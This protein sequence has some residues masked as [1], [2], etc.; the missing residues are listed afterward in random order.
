[1]IDFCR[2]GGPPEIVAKGRASRADL[3]PRSSM[4]L[5]RDAGGRPVRQH[6]WTRIQMYAKISLY[7]VCSPFILL[8]VVTYELE[9]P[10]AEILSVCGCVREGA[11]TTDAGCGK[12]VKLPTVSA[13]ALPMH[14]NRQSIALPSFGEAGYSQAPFDLA[15][16][17]C[18][19]QRVLVF[20]S[21][22]RRTAGL[23][24]WL[25]GRSLA[26]NPLLFVHTKRTETI[27]HNLLCTETYFGGVESVCVVRSQPNNISPIQA[28]V[29]WSDRC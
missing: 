9:S 8:S 26:H 17:V 13:I 7:S 29:D 14:L 20:F 3:A 22:I 27:S 10:S 28:V 15:R 2:G 18:R 5:S 1:M 21:Q 23:S 24:C 25:A 6:L 12:T 4:V 16:D 11:Q 19:C